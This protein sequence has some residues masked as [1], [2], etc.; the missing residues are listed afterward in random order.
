MA[1]LAL[2][3]F[4]TSL[5]EG[6]NHI[7]IK[8]NEELINEIT[9]EHV[10]VFDVVTQENSPKYNSDN[11]IYQSNVFTN[12]KQ[13]FVNNFKLF[14]TS[15]TPIA[16]VGEQTGTPVGPGIQ[17]QQTGGQQTC[18]GEKCSGGFMTTA[19]EYLSAGIKK[20]LG[21]KLAEIMN[22]VIDS[23][24]RRAFRYILSDPSIYLEVHQLYLERLK[25]NLKDDDATYQKVVSSFLNEEA[26]KQKLEENRKRI[27]EEI[28]KELE[29]DLSTISKN[30]GAREEL[31]QNEEK[32]LTEL[33]NQTEQ[34]TKNI[35]IL[36][37]NQANTIKT[38]TQGLPIDIN[39]NIGTDLS[40]LS[41]DVKAKLPILKSLLGLSE[42]E[43]LEGYNV[44]AKLAE[45]ENTSKSSTLGNLNNLFQS[46]T[47]TASIL[48]SAL[49]IPVAGFKGG[50]KT[51]RNYRK[52]QSQKIT[53]THRIHY[54]I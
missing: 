24:Y 32:Q 18:E 12:V 40:N 15:G 21:E 44:K 16:P 22:S 35:G 50:S 34:Y 9:K 45:L 43:K 25:E 54:A 52:N 14:L 46:K 31:K 47:N 2:S 53:K 49:A 38:L 10:F 30:Q 51:R 37:I 3:H 28:N 36:G 23:N 27:G 11:S 42:N 1:S 33:S 5:K 39:G 20:S 48:P 7:I 6:M 19:I 4:I 29:L 13:D 41:P 26:A 8:I 17:T